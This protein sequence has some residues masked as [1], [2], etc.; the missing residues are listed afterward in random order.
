MGKDYSQLQHQE[1]TRPQRGKQ[2]VETSREK[3]EYEEAHKKDNSSN[4]LEFVNERINK[5]FKMVSTENLETMVLVRN[6]NLTQCRLL[7]RADQYCSSI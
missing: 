5:L 2:G 1:L 3:P 4:K 7:C 6:I